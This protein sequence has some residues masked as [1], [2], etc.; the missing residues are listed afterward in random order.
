MPELAEGLLPFK[1]AVM[2]TWELVV[3]FV[4]FSRNFLKWEPLGFRR[5]ISDEEKWYAEN[6]KNQNLEMVDVTLV[7]TAP[8]LFIN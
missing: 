6:E 5:F 7:L 4:P 1:K 3:A 2:N 8:S